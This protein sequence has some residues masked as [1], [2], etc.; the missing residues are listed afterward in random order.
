MALSHAQKN[1]ADWL[2]LSNV[3]S[4]NTHPPPQKSNRPSLFTPHPLHALLSLTLS[5]SISPQ[6]RSSAIEQ[7][8]HDLAS[9]GPSQVQ[10]LQQQLPE[11]V[12][13]VQ[14]LLQDHNFKVVTAGLH[15][16]A[17]A[18]SSLGPELQHHMG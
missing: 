11:F 6:T 18:S 17:D 1:S 3:R 16:L 7:V 12:A 9:L 8:Q 2:L 4:Y 13:F 15:V 14:Q 5:I 10:V